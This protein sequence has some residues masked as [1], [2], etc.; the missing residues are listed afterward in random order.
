VKERQATTI[1]A[2]VVSDS[3][4][5]TSDNLIQ[6]MTVARYVRLSGFPGVLI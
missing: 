6:R 3:E 1:K 5:F 4:G 2:E